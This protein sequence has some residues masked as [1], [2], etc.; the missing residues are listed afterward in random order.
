MRPQPDVLTDIPGKP[1]R[2]WGDATRCVGPTRPPSWLV[3]LIGSARAHDV[4][5]SIAAIRMMWMRHAYEGVV[6]D[7]GASGQLFA[8]LQM[9]VPWGR[10]RHVM[11]DCN[12]YQSPSRIVKWLKGLRLRLASRSV[13]RFVVWASHEVE[14]YARVFGLPKRKLEY[15]PFHTTLNGY[16]YEVRDDGYL[17]AGGNYD[18]DYPLLVEAVRGL[19]VPTWIATTRPQQLSG[20][21]LP[22]NVRI[23]G[24]TV[25]G[26]R[27]AMAAARVVVV[28][29]ADGLLHSGGQQTVL[30]AMYMEKP[31]IAVGPKWAGDFIEDGH[32]GLLVNYGDGAGLRRAIRWV[33]EQPEAARVMGQRAKERASWFTTERTMRSVYR[34]AVGKS[35][36]TPESLKEGSHSPLVCTPGRRAS[37]TENRV[38]SVVRWPVGGIRTHIIYTYE[39]LVAAGYR[40]TFVVPDDASR[41]TF[42]RSLAHLPGCEFIGVTLKGPNCTMWPKVREQIA[43]RRYGLI[44]SHG[45]TAAVHT[46]IGRWG[47][48]VP[49]LATVHD[50]FRP[51][52][53][54]GLKGRFKQAIL[55]RL[56]KQIDTIASVSRDVQSN[57]LEY[58]PLVGQ[59]GGPRL[60]VVPNGID[61][62]HYRDLVP[63][64]VRQGRG[65]SLVLGFMGRFMEQKGFTHLLQALQR[66]RREGTSRPVHLVAVGSGDRR[67]ESEREIAERGLS[68]M[69]TIHDFVPDVLPLLQQIDVMV[70]PSLWEAS[71]LLSMEAMAVGVPVLGSNCIGL[72]EVLA[73]TPSR[74]FR[75]GD[76]DDLT[77]ALRAELDADRSAEAR[78]FA[79]SARERFD[80]RQYALRFRDEFDRMYECGSVMGA[81][82][83]GFGE[84]TSPARLSNA[85]A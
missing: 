84:L 76:V 43:T 80:V 57:L 63:H 69:V 83:K 70:V 3:R 35:Q 23:E 44:H 25:E 79:V 41:S 72:R 2:F 75:A 33:L 1:G 51:D 11:I 77:R 7:G 14:D 74:S 52:Q 40:F 62:Q 8:L 55:A 47:R 54:R 81:L 66:L 30:N 38:L 71:S 19:D 26:F 67:K 12:W 48:N 68:S 16:D 27:R 17:F 9:L 45:L 36:T 29:M 15:V 73:G 42:E 24:T 49:H 18:R 78:A 5:G 56:V 4:C 65:D 58:L 61:T 82:L 28:P 39:T 46:V 85:V 20:V 32:N 13:E 53:F 60:L 22:P 50:V 6:T 64:K 31:T 37:D 34:I 59:R 10:R 21:T